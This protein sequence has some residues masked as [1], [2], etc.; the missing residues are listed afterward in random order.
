MEHFREEGY[1]PEAMLNW[2]VRMGWTHGDQEVFSAEEIQDLFDLDHVGRGAAQADPKK[3]SHLNQLW[4][5]K[6][7]A[8]DLLRRMGPHLEA[9]A[10]G[11]VAPSESL[12]RLLDLLRERS[13]SLA[14]MAARA[15]FALLEPPP[16]DEQAAR[17]HL[18]EAASEP[19]R[20][21][22]AV[23]SEEPE[24]TEA[25]LEAAFHRVCEG[26]LDLKLGK[27]AQP[28]RVAVT[29]SSASPGIFETLVVLGRERTTTRL[30][31]ALATIEAAPC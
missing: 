10:G 26:P 30:Q 9:V 31:A 19:L 11:P 1:L 14:D 6:L 22:L 25:S 3:L 23:L 18:T 2:L 5:R 20:A 21:L 4:I 28:V 12:A 24:W 8:D 13:E 27:L 29:G 17:K 15:R 7:P 16:M